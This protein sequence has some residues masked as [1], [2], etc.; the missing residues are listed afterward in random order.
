MASVRG[1]FL[2]GILKHVRTSTKI[3]PCQPSK[4]IF[5]TLSVSPR[6]YKPRKL[7][8]ESNFFLSSDHSSLF[9]DETGRE[10]HDERVIFVCDVPRKTPDIK[11]KLRKHFSLFGEVEKVSRIRQDMMLVSFRSVESAS[12]ALKEKHL[13]EGQ[14]ITTL[15]NVKKGN[16][17][18]KSSKIKVENVPQN[19]SKEE[20]VNYFSEFGSVT[21]VDFI[22]IDP[23]TLQ[24]KSFCFVEFSSMDEAKKAAMVEDHKVGVRSLKVSLSTSK[25]SAVKNSKEIIVRSLPHD[26]TLDDLKEYFEQFGSL[27][28]IDLIYQALARPHTIYAFVKFES[29]HAAEQASA[30]LI[31]RICDKKTVVQKSALPY[32]IKNGDRKL[33][34]EGF[35]PGT[36]PEKVRAYFEEFGK[37]EHVNK[38]AIH[39]TGKTFVVFKSKV[40]LQH[41]LQQ[42]EHVL[43]GRNLR[44]R[45]VLWRK[46][47]IESIQLM[48]MDELIE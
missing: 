1:P 4:S 35:Q 12:K 32:P 42:K 36:D 24:R 18:G 34:V 5:W 16:W 26:I 23:D 9:S 19:M 46:P 45:P 48:N 6:P 43:D 20:L 39:P 11:G 37:L 44:I 13:L 27:E 30:T 28:Q 15:P 2:F 22:F 14:W 8:H 31:H 3:N 29:P 7:G 47:E 38:T 33:F 40:S 10:L 17:K 21:S 25:L 41:V